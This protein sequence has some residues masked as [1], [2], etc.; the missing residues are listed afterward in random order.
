MID[1][2]LPVYVRGGAKVQCDIAKFMFDVKCTRYRS[3]FSETNFSAK[4]IPRIWMWNV[5]G[6]AE[7]KHT[8]HGKSQECRI[9]HAPISSPE[10]SP[11]FAVAEIMSTIFSSL[12]VR[13]AL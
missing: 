12:T 11:T 8:S 5:S 4:N 2:L 1:V 9:V 10:L 13:V 7:N 6:N 3:M